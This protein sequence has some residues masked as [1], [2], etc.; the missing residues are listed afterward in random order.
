MIDS[1]LL[2]DFDL[3]L[4][5]ELRPCDSSDLH[6][7]QLANDM[8]VFSMPSPACFVASQDFLCM[9]FIFSSWKMF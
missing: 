6:M 4:L 9:V 8:Y 5:D 2:K 1:G 7:L 3:A